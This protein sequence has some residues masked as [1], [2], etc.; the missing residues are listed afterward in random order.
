MA[1]TMPP[2]AVLS[3]LASTTPVTPTASR[4]MARLGEG[5]LAGGRVEHQ[6]RLVRRLVHLLLGDAGELFQLLHQV[7]LGVQAAGGVD[8]QHIGVARL[9]ARMAS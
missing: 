5:V 1:K 7:V 4:E 9:A 2:L 8:D 6:Q 3:S